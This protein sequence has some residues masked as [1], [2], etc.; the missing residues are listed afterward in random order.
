MPENDAVDRPFPCHVK[1]QAD[2]L[3]SSWLTRLSLVHG[4]QPRTFATI[5]WPATQI[6]TS[7]TDHHVTSEMLAILAQKTSTSRPRAFAT[8]LRAYEGILWERSSSYAS[9]PW[10][11]RNGFQSQRQ[12]RPG[13]QF[14]PKCLQADAMPYFR[15][16]WRLGFVTVCRAHQ[17]RLLDRCPACGAPVNFHLLPHDTDTITRCYHCQFDLVVA[18]SPSLDASS[19][20]QRLAAFQTSILQAMTTGWYQLAEDAVV[21]LFQFLRVLRYLVR[22]LVMHEDANRL[23]DGFCRRLEQPYFIPCLPA[24]TYRLLEGLSVTDRFQLLL[25]VAWWLEDWPEQFVTICFDHLIGPHHLLRHMSSPPSWYEQTVQQVSGETALKR[26]IE[27]FED[28]L[29]TL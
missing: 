27:L 11:L 10:L 2:E 17:R 15:R 3:L 6:W 29:N 13:L 18:E 5:L 9:R 12:A 14:C 23:R 22:L 19:A 25:L 26:A 1:P 7:D 28:A 20:D 24:S 16:C 8:S 4:L 21:R